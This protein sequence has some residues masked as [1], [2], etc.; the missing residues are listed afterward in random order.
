[1]IFLSLLPAMTDMFLQD[2]TCNS[3]QKFYKVFM[4]RDKR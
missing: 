1:M 3:A 2:I 4:K